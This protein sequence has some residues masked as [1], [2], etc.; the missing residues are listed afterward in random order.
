MVV[1]RLKY[2]YYQKFKLTVLKMWTAL[3]DAV[4]AI[5]IENWQ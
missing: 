3:L 2:G 5:E 4:K 1:G